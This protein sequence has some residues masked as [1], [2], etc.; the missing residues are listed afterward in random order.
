MT[1]GARSRDRISL[2]A[3][4]ARCASSPTAAAMDWIGL[5][6][7]AE[8]GTAIIFRAVASIVSPTPIG[9][10]GTG[11]STSSC[12]VPATEMVRLTP[13]SSLASICAR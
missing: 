6:R 3:G 7:R 10:C 11:T 4:K 5:S 12:T 1:G 8:A 13:P 9:R 2:P